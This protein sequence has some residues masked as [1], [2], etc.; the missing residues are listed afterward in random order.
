MIRRLLLISILS[1]F[2]LIAWSQSSLEGKVTDATTGEPVMF[3]NVIL[4]K[5]GNQITGTTTDLNGNY[6]FSSMDAGTYDV[7]VI[8]TGYPDQRRTGVVVYEGKAITLDFK[9]DAGLLLG[10]AIVTA[11]K[12]PLIEK[13]NTTQGGIKTAEQIRN[14]PTKNINAI[15]ATTAGLSSIDGGKPNIRGS[16]D[17]ATNYYIDG[18][19]VSS[20]N[21]I[22]QSEIEQLQVITGGIE[23]RY[24]DVTGGLISL[25]SKGPSSKLSG[26]IELESSEL[27]DPY[28]Y[29][30]LD[31]NVS[32]PILKNKTTNQTILGFRVSGQYRKRADSDPQAF[33][34][35]RATADAIARISAHPVTSINGNP[36]LLAERLE[37]SDVELLKARPNT[38]ITRYDFTGKLDFRVND[39][40][41]L[42]VGGSYFKSTQN[43]SPNRAWDLLNWQN[44]PYADRNGYLFNFRFRHRIGSNVTDQTNQV[45]PALIRNIS[46]SL[47]YGYEKNKYEEGDSRYRDD[48][49]KYGYIGKFDVSWVPSVGIASDT[50][51]PYAKPLFPGSELYGEHFGSTETF[52][53]EGYTPSST[54]NPLL[55]NYNEGQDVTNFRNYSAYNG[56]WSNTVSSV[57]SSLHTST[58]AI[59][60][61]FDKRDDDI[62]TGTLNASFD[63]FPG[64]SDKGRHNIQFGLIYE[65]RQTRRWVMNPRDLWNT[66][67]LAANDV[68]IVGLDSTQEIGTAPLTIFMDGRLDTFDITLFQ[69]LVVEQPNLLFYKKVRELTGQ[70]LHDF[71]N[72]DGL[73]PDNLSLD[74]FAAEELTNRKQIDYNGYDYLG[75]KLPFSV[76]FD[77]FFTTEDAEGRRTLPVAANKPNYS[78]AY[79]QDKFTFK[80]IIFRLGLRVD[81]YDAN[82]KVLKD[83]YSLYE[84]I[85]AN[86]FYGLPDVNDPRPPAVQDDWKVYVVSDGSKEVRA[87]RDG[88]QWYTAEGSPVNDGSEILGNEIPN[89]YY[90]EQNSANRNIKSR[91]FDPNGSFVDYTPQVSWMP[92]LAFSFPISD[93]ANFF[94]HYDILVQRPPSNT[95]ATALDYYYWADGPPANNP[96]LKPEKTIDF[97][98]GF[99]QKIT[100]SSAITLSAYYKEL[101]DMIQ[102]R[103]YLFVPGIPGNNYNSYGNQDFGTVKGFS[104]AYDLR[105]TANLEMTAAYTLQFADGT[106]SDADSQG[107]LNSRG[108]VRYLSPLS[109]DERHRIAANIDFRYGK[110]TQYN[111]PRWFGKDVFSDAGVSLQANA[112]SGRPYTHEQKSQIYGSEGVGGAINGARLPWNFSLDLRV[113]K[114]FSLLGEQA[115][116]PMF[117][118]VYLRVENLLDARNII[119]VYKASGSP[120]DDGFLVT[121]DGRSTIETLINSNREED[122]DNFLLS[123]QWGLLNP[124]FYTLPRRI[125]LGAQI[126]F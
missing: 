125:Y 2:G 28:G 42:T 22:P 43:F 18:I 40:I 97:E 85:S 37:S 47:Q 119:G 113:D 3:A 90:V 102:S 70:S 100:N 38:D 45:A 96:D 67:R 92:R 122:V 91:E 114:S 34:G 36:L 61:R 69:T 31:G 39:D 86:D 12:V 64:G 77:D 6:V 89:P 29:N 72:I 81:R 73:D 15:A 80:D 110:G 71:V 23:S 5:N 52:S 24:G 49:F 8:F 20:T 117:A 32:G 56:F 17:N 1:S 104:F 124:G 115:Q 21:L 25:T 79:I 26:S 94:V 11:Y 66:M 109:F 101:R 63:L 30:L 76:S 120:Y 44:N 118:N 87:F 95:I 9:M 13:D 35:Y 46:Y 55:N 41:D 33:G 121:Q 59:Y 126:Q 4:F 78:A 53:S 10:E 57:Y 99:K 7:L 112:A 93:D 98:V 83:P 74:M 60:N 88:D 27:T 51:S 54:I 19:R 123:Y 14:L 68:H 107:S 108:N 65:Q 58:G 82:T 111:G 62:H 105:R 84:V 75:N 106:G 48:L 16:R 116:H 103:K 50:S